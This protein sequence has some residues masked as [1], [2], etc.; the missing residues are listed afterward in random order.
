MKKILLIEDDTVMRENT[1]EILELANFD[2]QTAENGKKGVTLAKEFCPDIIICDIMMPE[3]DGYGVLH[4]LSKEPSTS[5]I[6]FIFLTAKAE[7][8]EVRKGM[9]LGADDYLTKPFEETE[10]LNAIEMRFKKVE[11]FKKKFSQDLDGLDQFLDSA[12]GLKELEALS[13]EKRIVKYKKKQIVFHEG[14]KPQYLYFISKGKVKT[15]KMHDDG[16]EYVTNVS[17]AGDFFGLTPLFENKP[18]SDSAILLEDSEVKKIPKE[19]FLS[20]IYKNRDVA[21]QFMKILSSNV[22]EREKQLLSLAYDSVRKRTA[23]VLV[24]LE[25]RYS[26]EGNS[27][28]EIVVTREDLAGMA[29]TATETVIRCLSDFKEDNLI[30]A[31][32]RKIVVLNLEGLKEVQ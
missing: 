19:D 23:E 13:Q 29:G 1:A 11:S 9:E 12:R 32:G 14:D 27:E 3:L 22:D 4:M 8:S 28:T 17:K 31:R 21:A 5:A 15:Y 30:E 7:K 16:K 26:V 24:N 10:L 18:Y 2:I 6:P 20:L 25:K